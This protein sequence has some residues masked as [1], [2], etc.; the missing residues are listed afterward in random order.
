MRP[1]N[2]QGCQ[3]DR[4]VLSK[5]VLAPPLA[6]RLPFLAG[7][8]VSHGLSPALDVACM[9]FTQLVALDFGFPPCP[10]LGPRIGAQEKLDPD[11]PETNQ[12]DVSKGRVSGRVPGGAVM[13]RCSCCH[14]GVVQELWCW[15]GVER[16]SQN[17]P[18]KKF[19][20]EPGSRPFAI[21]DVAKPRGGESFLVCVVRCR[22]CGVCGRCSCCGVRGAV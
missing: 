11:Y 13:V 4:R 22:C 2:E 3:R 16:H 10:A 20:C 17:F 9:K 5:Y 18:P 12:L 19:R 15:C 7:R 6:S 21:H 14:V 1:C 8:T